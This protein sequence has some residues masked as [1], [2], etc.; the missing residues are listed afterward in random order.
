MEIDSR[1][2]PLV[3]SV[4]N[5]AVK[6]D[7]EQFTASMQQFKDQESAKKGLQLAVAIC[8]YVLFDQYKRR[9]TDDEISRILKSAAETE[10][11]VELREG[12]LREALMSMLDNREP[13]LPSPVS[14]VAPFVLTAYLLAGSVKKPKWWFEYL[15][16]VLAGLEANGIPDLRV[17]PQ[18]GQ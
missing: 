13:Q 16:E 5:A 8:L 18:S 9:P 15:D 17:A 14:V 2:E 1:V 4:L 7:F 6:T 10:Q 12:E 11:W 3:R